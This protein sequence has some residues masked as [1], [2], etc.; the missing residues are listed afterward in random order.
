MQMPDDFLAMAPSGSG[1]MVRYEGS[2][3]GA[4]DSIRR[5]NKEMSSQQTIYNDQTMESVISDSM[6]ARRFAMILLGAFAAL[7]LGLAS[8]GIYGVIAYVVGERTQEIGIRMALGAR[9]KDVLRLVLWQGTRLALLGAAIGLGAALILTRL[10]TRLLYGV[11][12]TDPATFAG[13]AAVL[14]VVAVAACWIPARKAMRVDPVVA[15][16]YE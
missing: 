16:R 1:V 4:L 12:A 9:Q 5:A 14:I 15:L 10:M 3:S 6:A 13:L 11:S 7:A 2:L 8:V